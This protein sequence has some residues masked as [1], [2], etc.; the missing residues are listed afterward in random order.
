MVRT[1][2]CFFGELELKHFF[3]SRKKRL[4]GGKGDWYVDVA[5]I[6]D[7]L[8]LMNAHCQWRNL[9]NAWHLL[10]TAAYGYSDQ[11]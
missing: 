11:I 9:Q 2:F 10:M 7:M 1:D 6:F 8:L 3:W 4:L 5:A